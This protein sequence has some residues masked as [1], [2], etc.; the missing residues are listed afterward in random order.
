MTDPSELTERHGNSEQADWDMQFLSAL[1]RMLSERPWDTGVYE[2]DRLEWADSVMT[3]V[4]RVWRGQNSRLVGW[5]EHLPTIRSGFGIASP[6]SI[7]GAWHT[8]EFYPCYL[9]EP[10]L[11]D[12]DGIH[13]VG[14]GR[15]S[16]RR[17]PK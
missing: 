9:P 6:A 10:F 1:T 3:L 5:R 7:A 13:W 12:A 16:F 15:P 4:V 2:V 8:G 11:P 14:R 17:A